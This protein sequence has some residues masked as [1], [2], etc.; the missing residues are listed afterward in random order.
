M[1][2]AMLYAH[3]KK[4]G[5]KWCTPESWKLEFEARGHKV[6]VYNLYHDDGALNPRKNV[7]RYSDEGLTALYWA[8]PT[9]KYDVVYVLD[10]G[11]FQSLKL[12]EANFPGAILIK[13]AG[14]SPQSHNMHLQTAYLFDLVL[15]PDAECVEDYKRRGINALWQTHF[16]DERVFYPRPEI[17]P[18]FDCVTTCGPRGNGLTETIKA[19]L[20]D[21]FN[22][23]RYF[24]G[25]DHAKRLCM[26]KIVFQRSQFGEITRRIFEGMACGKMVLTD[27]LSSDKKLDQ[28]FTDGVDI[29]YYDNAADAIEKIRYYSEHDAERE[30]IAA[31]GFAKVMAN[32]TVAARVSELEKAILP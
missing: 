3:W 23:E 29:V 16:A 10:Y 22:N 6:D 32:H 8:H 15:T 21:R 28:L 26:G 2:I 27:R 17:V 24:Y 18:C 1:K 30:Q 31:N 11:P 25:E 9:E 4:F 14:D 12:N 13:E 20:G 5:E 19:E 7:R